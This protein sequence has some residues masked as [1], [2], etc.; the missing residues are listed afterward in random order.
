[1]VLSIQKLKALNALGA[2][3][4]SAFLI[5]ERLVDY[6]DLRLIDSAVYNNIIVYQLDVER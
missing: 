1:M 4:S 5:T 6:G 2:D 3:E